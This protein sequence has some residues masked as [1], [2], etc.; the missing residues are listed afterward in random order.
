LV[1]K[2]VEQAGFTPDLRSLHNSADYLAIGPPELLAAYQ[3]VLE[4]RAEQGIQGMAIPIGAVYDQFSHGMVDPQA[5]RAL[6]G[7]A[8]D[9]WAGSPKYLVLVGD[10][11]YD[12]RGYQTAPQ[13]NQVPTFFVQTVH[14]G[15]TAS[16]YGFSIPGESSWQLPG[17]QPSV[18]PEI[19]VGRIPA[20]SPDEVKAYVQKVLAYEQQAGEL[21]PENPWQKRILAVADGSDPGFKNDAEVFLGNIPEDF[22]TEL[23]APQS[24]E[25]GVNQ[26]VSARINQ[27]D[28]L[29]AYFGHGSI[30]LWGKDRLFTAQDIPDLNNFDRLPV[31][32]NFTCLNGLFTHPKETSLAD[33]FLWQP[34]GGAVAVLAP[35]S[36]TLPEDQSYLSNSLAK[37][38]I[39]NPDARLGELLTRARNQ[40]LAENPSDRDVLFT[41]LLFGDPA[42]KLARPAAP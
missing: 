2:I 19:A 7:Y 26:A 10:A 21:D 38:L 39:G 31:I 35:T 8:K 20:R 36:L 32:L 5:I 23:L 37:E 34:G 24:G 6:L 30:N 14:G 28:W 12:T 9:N 29:V 33:A 22:Q 42:L 15:E 11:S 25:Q 13:A 4:L 41:F 3:P 18:S 27:G 40:M 1:P 17:E 16:D